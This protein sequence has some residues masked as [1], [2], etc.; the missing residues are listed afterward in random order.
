MV[1]HGIPFLIKLGECAHGRGIAMVQY[2]AR[3]GEEPPKHVHDSEDE[4]FYIQ[5]AVDVCVEK[6]SYRVWWS[7]SIACRYT[8]AVV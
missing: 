7:N 4:V 8:I 2:T 1:A 3:H 5:R 6:N